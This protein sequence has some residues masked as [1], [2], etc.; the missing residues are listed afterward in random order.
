MAAL[1][2]F[3]ATMTTESNLPFLFDDWFVEL[4]RSG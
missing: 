1:L 4:Q 2:P 3:Q